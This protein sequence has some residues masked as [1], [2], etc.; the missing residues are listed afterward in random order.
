MSKLNIRV[1]MSP[2][3]PNIP[4]RIVM[5][6]KRSDSIAAFY[7]EAMM[8]RLQG[9]PNE[10]FK[11]CNPKFKRLPIT[12]SGRVI[13]LA[14]WD[15]QTAWPNQTQVAQCVGVSTRDYIQPG[16][17]SM[18]L[19]AKARKALSINPIISLSEITDVK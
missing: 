13:L 2:R 11:F 10:W 12:E 1:Y 19:L 9:Y 14:Y 3:Y 8:N 4:D 18:A 6:Y 5:S 15:A 17:R 7:G 16:R